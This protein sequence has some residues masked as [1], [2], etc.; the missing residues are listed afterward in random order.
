M[1]T[2]TT[3]LITS[4]FPLIIGFIW[5]NPK[6][7]GNFW[8][9]VSEVT[10]EK[11]KTGNF[12]GILIMTYVL[13]FLISAFMMGVVIHQSHLYSIFAN[14]PEAQNPDTEIGKYFADFMAKYGTLFRTFKHGAFH[15]TLTGIFFATPIVAINAMFERRGFKYIM[16]HAGFW[17]VTLALMGGMICQF[18]MRS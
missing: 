10:E 5:Y 12:V 4:L 6:V 11:L 7:F 13:G 3:L 17:I 8:M 2:I 16:V 9:R 1:N 18:A 15:G 14:M